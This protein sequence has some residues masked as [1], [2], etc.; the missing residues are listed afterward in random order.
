MYVYTY[1]TA[2]CIYL[3]LRLVLVFMVSLLPFRLLAVGIN[4]L[5]VAACTG[6]SNGIR[7]LIN[8]EG[9][10][11][12]HEFQQ[13]VTALHEACEGGHEECVEILIELGAEVNKQVS[14]NLQ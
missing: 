9:F 5:L 4:Q 6:D 1:T 13:G 8:E 7:A 11:P 3:L 2:A 12:S 14:S 10:S